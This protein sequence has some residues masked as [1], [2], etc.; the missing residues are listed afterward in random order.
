GTI[1]G[2][3]GVNTLDYSLYTTGITVDLGSGTAT[4]VGGGITHI[5]NVTGGAGNDTLTG[6]AADNVLIGNAG[7]DTVLGGSDGNAILV[8]GLGNDILTAGI[9]RSLL[10]G[11]SGT[12][13]L[14]GGSADDI[15]I[16]GSTS[17]D[18]NIGALQAIMTEWKRT[19]LDYAGR[20]NHLRGTTTGG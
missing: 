3:A 12:D 10:I 8:G 13:N 2:G 5:Q 1:D 7:N 11:G 15:L 20:I 6:D 17:Y 19:D 18:A 4:G 16:G 14:L 9:G